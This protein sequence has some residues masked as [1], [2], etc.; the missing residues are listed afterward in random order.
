M[1]LDG[2]FGIGLSRPLEG[3]AARLAERSHG[4]LGE[5]RTRLLALDAP[6]GILSEGSAAGESAGAGAGG[7]PHFVADSTLVFVAAKPCHLLQPSR[8]SCGTIYLDDLGLPQPLGLVRA[9][10]PALWGPAFA[11]STRREAESHKHRFGHAVVAAGALPGAALLAGGAALRVGAG[12]VTLAGEGAREGAGEGG[13]TTPSLMFHD[14][15]AGGAFATWLAEDPRRNAVVLGPGLAPGAETMG[16]V[17]AVLG[18][19]P[20]RGV[21]LDAGALTAFADAPEALFALTRA[22]AEAGGAAVLTPHDGEYARLAGH[23]GAGEAAGAG[24]GASRLARAAA[25]A[26][27]SGAVV[28]LKGS[29]AVV[30][31]PDGRAAISCTAP[32]WLATAGTGD[33]LAGLIAGLLACRMPPWEAASA[34]LWLQGEAA[35]RLGPGLV[36]E[37]LGRALPP[38]LSLLHAAP[39]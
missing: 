15:G 29:D 30:A 27:A 37:D 19:A 6:S 35:C 39:L 16:L 20:P 22:H 31:A 24:A 9:N 12:L 11:A 33:V 38:L 18:L 14:T 10:S 25:L 21:V 7:G 36:A 13:G 17:G 1:V 8:A 34:A 5:G 28:L 32:P 2:L 3:A 4:L 26:E 23:S